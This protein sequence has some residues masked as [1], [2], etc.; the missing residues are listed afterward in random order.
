MQE[1]TKPAPISKRWK[2]HA[3]VV[4][5]MGVMGCGKSSLGEALAARVAGRFFEGDLEHPPQNLEKM[6][7]GV[8]LTDADRAPWL[9]A[10]AERAHAHRDGTTPIVISC[11]ALKRSYRMQLR[12]RIGMGLCF[13][14]LDVPK[15]VIVTRIAARDDHFMPATLIDSQFASLEPPIGEADVLQVSLADTPHQL[16]Q[17]IRWLND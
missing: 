16:D 4:I 9:Q 3:P 7:A 12:E 15:P 8:P 11:S 6:Q 2:N 17:I 10:I 14:W 13:V 1:Q 5:T